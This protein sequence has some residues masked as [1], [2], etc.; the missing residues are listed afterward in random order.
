MKEKKGLSL[1]LLILKIFLCT[2][3]SLS[4]VLFL[5]GLADAYM[6]SISLPE[7]PPSGTVQID[8]LPLY[9]A[10]ALI[11]S[12][13]PMIPCFLLAVT[14]LIIS[15]FYKSS[16]KKKRN[17]VIFSLLSAFPPFYYIVIFI[18]GLLLAII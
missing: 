4:F 12:L 16:P 5:V 7:N 9:F 8:P 10:L 1:F 11:L 2:V 14:G 17:R 18:L 6:D 13:Y 15:V 3:L